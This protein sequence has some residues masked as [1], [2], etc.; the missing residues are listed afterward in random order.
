MATAPLLRKTG[1]CILDQATVLKTDR[2]A[3]RSAAAFRVPFDMPAGAVADL[4]LVERF[5]KTDPVTYRQRQWCFV[6]IA[7]DRRQDD[8]ITP[9]EAFADSKILDGS[10]DV[11]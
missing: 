5:S 3:K 8:V 7:V 10:D 1:P 11:A 2:Q 6:T 9:D 4:V